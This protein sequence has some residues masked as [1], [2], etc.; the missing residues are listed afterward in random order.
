MEAE[1]TGPGVKSASALGAH[2]DIKNDLLIVLWILT[3]EEE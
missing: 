2:A 1:L 3:G